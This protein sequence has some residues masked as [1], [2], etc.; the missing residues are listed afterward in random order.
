MIVVCPNIEC[1]QK[2]EIK[3]EML[4]RVVKCK[5]CNLVFKA[6]IEEEKERITAKETAKQKAYKELDRIM[7]IISEYFSKSDN[8]ND[9]CLII[10]FLLRYFLDHAISDNSSYI[11]G[12]IL[13]DVLS[14]V[15]RAYVKKAF[16][17]T[18]GSKKKAAKLL[19]INTRSLRYRLDKFNIL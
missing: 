3:V 6:G 2:Y 19:G 13:D 15:E 18:G 17:Q 9:P 16:E 4:G 1:K 10:N 14:E 12:L 5:K 8:R 7:P 11:K